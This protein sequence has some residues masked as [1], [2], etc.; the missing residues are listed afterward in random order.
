MVSSLHRNV[1]NTYQNTWRHIT[2]YSNLKVQQMLHVQCPYILVRVPVTGPVVAQKVGRGIALLFTVA[3]EGGEWL[4]SCPCRTLL[5]GKTR[6][7]FYSKLGESQ[8][9]SGRAENLAP[10]G[11]ETRNVQ[12]VVSRYTDWATR[13]TMSLYKTT[14]STHVGYSVQEFPNGQNV[15]RYL[16]A[17]IQRVSNSN[18]NSLWRSDPFN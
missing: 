17:I 7:P 10:P 14:S 8:G 11:F 3:L 13:P 5:P 12:P 15:A 2:E 18:Y 16:T 6:Y 9:Q 1:G 4:A